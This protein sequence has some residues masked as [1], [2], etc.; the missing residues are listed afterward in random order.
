MRENQVCKKIFKWTLPVI[1]GGLL[2]LAAY[3]GTTKIKGSGSPVVLPPPAFEVGLLKLSRP[4]LI[5]GGRYVLPAET[6]PG[7]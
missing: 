4:D 3:G 5:R 2:I 1:F 7:L 6:T